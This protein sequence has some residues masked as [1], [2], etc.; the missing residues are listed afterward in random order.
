LARFYL[1]RGG[2]LDYRVGPSLGTR[3]LS[4]KKKE[5]LK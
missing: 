5:I 4:Q 3:G 2:A 1:C